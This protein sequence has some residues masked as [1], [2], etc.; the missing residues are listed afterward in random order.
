[1]EE[2][3]KPTKADL[4]RVLALLGRPGVS[5]D[6]IAAF[7]AEEDGAEYAVWLVDC[8]T[9]KAVLKRAKEC[10]IE[11]YRCYFSEKKPYVPEFFGDCEYG[12]DRYFLTGYCPGETLSRCTREKLVPALDALIAMQDEFWERGELYPA[13]ITL[14]R[15]LRAVVD[16]GEYLASPL[17]ERTYAVFARAY[18][19]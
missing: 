18:P 5:E 13:C 16:R 12:G 14:E 1:M 11:A 8:G 19:E 2:K 9:E 4:V 6:A 10:E 15:A 17:L 3:Q 7:T